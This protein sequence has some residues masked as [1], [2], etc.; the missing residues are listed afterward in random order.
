MEE[1]VGLGFYISFTCSLTFKNASRA[2]DVAKEVPAER[3]LLE[4]D[5][6]FLAPQAFRGKRNEPAYIT[7]LLDILSEIRGLSKEEIARITTEN[8]N[9][10]F[11]F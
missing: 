1:A 10:L 4:T 7:H 5:A 8:A 6:P 9:E 11:K 3:L 2:R